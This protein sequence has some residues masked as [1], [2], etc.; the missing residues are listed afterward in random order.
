M[1]ELGAALIPK[2]SSTTAS[3]S[4]HASKRD[5]S[6][7][8]ISGNPSVTDPEAS[9]AFIKA[10]IHNQL[11]PGDAAGRQT[12]QFDPKTESLKDSEVHGQTA[13]A[14]KNAE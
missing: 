6:M 4:E 11:P 7:P 13:K 1:E 14:S 8:V 10:Q 9:V 5:T 12:N 2:P 3:T